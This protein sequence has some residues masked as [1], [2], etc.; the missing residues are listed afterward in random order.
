MNTRGSHR[1]QMTSDQVHRS[2]I[3]STDK[4]LGIDCSQPEIF[5]NFGTWILKYDGANGRGSFLT[6]A[7]LKKYD[8]D[9]RYKD[10]NI[11]RIKRRPDRKAKSLSETEISDSS[12][13]AENRNTK[14]VCL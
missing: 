7:N 6:T 10:F 4:S 8:E 2:L 12:T 1:R 3:L 13:F 5:V 14:S 11:K 9:N